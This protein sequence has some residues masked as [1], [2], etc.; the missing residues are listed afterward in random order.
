[1]TFN[2]VGINGRATSIIFRTAQ[3]FCVPFQCAARINT[4]GPLRWAMSM[5]SSSRAV[6]SVITGVICGD[7]ESFF[8]FSLGATSQC[9]TNRR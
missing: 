8:T 4:R 9:A 6:L 2:W 7:I 3:I 1:M 5:W